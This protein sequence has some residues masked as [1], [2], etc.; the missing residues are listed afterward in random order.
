M[1]MPETAVNENYRTVT[2]ENQVWSTSH[3]SLVQPKTESKSVNHR[4]DD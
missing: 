3:T 1:P 2:R 4:T